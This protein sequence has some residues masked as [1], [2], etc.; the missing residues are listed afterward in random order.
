M[1]YLDYVGWEESYEEM[2]MAAEALYDYEREEKQ[3]K[4]LEEQ[5]NGSKI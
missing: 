2:I 4:R 1:D 5:S 3:L